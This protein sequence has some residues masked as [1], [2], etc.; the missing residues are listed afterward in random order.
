MF[1]IV[2]WCHCSILFLLVLFLLVQTDEKARTR[3]HRARNSCFTEYN[4]GLRKVIRRQLDLH[5]VTRNDPNKVLS[6]LARNMCENVPPIWQVHPEHCAR[7][8][9]GNNSFNLYGI[10]LGHVLYFVPMPRDRQLLS[11]P[12][13]DLPSSASVTRAFVL[14]AGLGTRLKLLT[15]RCPKP[16]IP[17]YGK[18]LITFAFDQ[19]IAVGA[20]EIVVNTHHCHEAYDRA[21]PE[22]VY[23]GTRLIFEHEPVLL[24][25]A[26]G[27]K[28][29]ERHFGGEGFIV[30]NGDVLTNLPLDKALA[31]HRTSGNEVTMVLRSHAGP[32][33]IT[34]QNERVVDIA[35]R[36]EV[37]GQRHLFT[38]LYIVEPEFLRRIP[39]RTKISVIPLFMEM[40]KE[41]AKLGGVVLDEGFWWDLGTREKYIE[42]HRALATADTFSSGKQWRTAIDVSACV[43]NDARLEG[44]VAVGSKA[45]IEG[46]SQVT[47]CILWDGARV[48]AGSVL[49]RCIVTSGRTAAGRQT[50]IDF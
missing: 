35:G 28:N 34:L 44:I 33:H 1:F 2:A 5:S 17:I 11:F 18:P 29:V 14:G 21:F 24:E 6:H 10:F 31:H 36:L 3:F 50:G 25:T 15:E 48:L 4:A 9:R 39:E 43:A 27:I 38:G 37:E 19:L 41:G 32:L 8:D 26:G 20:T 46:G 12:P 45:V 23:R 30:Y 22:A 47:D 7:E 16:L 42:V 40:I 13:E 49:N